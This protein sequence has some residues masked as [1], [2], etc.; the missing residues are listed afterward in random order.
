MHRKL[1]RL[2]TFFF[3]PFFF[4]SISS[5]KKLSQ[6]NKSDFKFIILFL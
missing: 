5:F 6:F 4:N 3:L 2:K 1:N